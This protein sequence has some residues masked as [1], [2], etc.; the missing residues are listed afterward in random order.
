MILKENKI[1]YPNWRQRKMYI[2]YEENKYEGIVQ[3]IV[4]LPIFRPVVWGVSS[5]DKC[6]RE[7]HESHTTA[8]TTAD[9]ITTYQI[10]RRPTNNNI[11]QLQIWSSKYMFIIHY[12]LCLQ[13]YGNRRSCVDLDL[14]HRLSINNY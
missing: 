7:R 10:W 14:I 1:M 11:T 8:K 3:R 12:K 5:G 9:Q 2:T 13:P 4:T 6:N